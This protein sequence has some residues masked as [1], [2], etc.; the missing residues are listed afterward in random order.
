M[1]GAVVNGRKLVLILLQVGEV[2]GTDSRLHLEN[3]GDA[4]ALM[5]IS[6]E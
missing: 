6:R 3:K 2:F 4:S 1:R 5:S